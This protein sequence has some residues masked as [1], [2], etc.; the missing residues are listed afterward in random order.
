[1]N[2]VI[3]L[4]LA[5]PMAVWTGRIASALVLLFPLF[6]AA[7][8]LMEI[9]PVTDAFNQLGYRVTVARPIGLLVLACAVL[10]A[11]PYTAILGALLPLRLPV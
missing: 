3:T 5:T 11:V 9:G 7:I 8:K 1:M 10:Y 4:V 6:D 2:P